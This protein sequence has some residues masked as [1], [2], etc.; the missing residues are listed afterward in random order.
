V[1]VDLLAAKIELRP[2]STSPFW[3]TLRLA[4]S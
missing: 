2:G 1:D 3:P 4:T